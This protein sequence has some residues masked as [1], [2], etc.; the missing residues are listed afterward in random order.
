MW[1]GEQDALVLGTIEK[2]ENGE[3]TIDVAKCLYPRGIIT[4]DFR[5]LSAEEVPQTIVVNHL[6]DYKIS[7]NG[8]TQPEEGDSIIVSLDKGSENWEC[9]Y[10]PLE[11]SGTDYETLELTT[12]A[13]ETAESFAWLTFIRT[14]GKIN[15]FQ[16]Y[17]CFLL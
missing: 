7:Y 10:S 12:P 3:Y 4:D 16:F 17:I 6:L 8:K 5:Q 11:V 2:E 14:D 1:H 9:N 13:N 15:E